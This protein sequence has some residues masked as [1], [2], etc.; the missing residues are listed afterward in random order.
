FAPDV[1]CT[2]VIFHLFSSFVLYVLF[3]FHPTPPT[4]FFPFSL[5]DALPILPSGM[6]SMSGQVAVMHGAQGKYW[7][8]AG[9]GGGNV[10]YQLILDRKSTRLNSSHK[11]ISYAVS[12]LKKKKRMELKSLRV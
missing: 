1:T 8:S 4:T 9:I 10:A 3:S 2:L 5:P 6:R 11:I 7:L 12:C